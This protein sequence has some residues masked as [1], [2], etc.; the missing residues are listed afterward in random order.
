MTTLTDRAIVAGRRVELYIHQGETYHHNW[1]YRDPITKA[2]INLTGY[3][4]RLQMRAAPSAVTVLYEATTAN[5]VI[6][7][8]APLGLVKLKIPA[9]SNSAWTF[10]AA[11]YDLEIQAATG[12]VDKL[13]WGRV[14]IKPEYTR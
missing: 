3:I 10:F 7:L 6:T 11:G 9:V 8:D 14:R 13:G 2:P 4:A 12:E 1:Q 5:G